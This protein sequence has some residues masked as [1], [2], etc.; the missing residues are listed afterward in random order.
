MGI[1]VFTSFAAT[2][3]LYEGNRVVGVA[4]G[5]KGI[6]ANKDSTL[7]CS[8]VN[9]FFQ[10]NPQLKPRREGKSE[11]CTD[12]ISAGKQAKLL[13]QHGDQG[14]DANKDGALTC[15]E[16][17]AF[18]Q[19]NPQL[20]SRREHDRTQNCTDPIPS[21]KQARML[22]RFGDKGIDANKDGTLTCDEMKAFYD[23]RAAER[24]A[25]TEQQTDHHADKKR[26]AGSG[27]LRGA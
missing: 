25:K 23:A 18:F 10:A 5:D 22:K 12:P 27:W 26:A 13:K 24:N 8:E 3:V 19:A 1:N 11:E 16:V 14:I 21:E 6:D 9:A 2:E 7:L 4:T 17:N 15:T 20:K